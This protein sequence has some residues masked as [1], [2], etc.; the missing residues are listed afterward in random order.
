[1]PT[2][3]FTDALT[4]KDE[5]FPKKPDKLLEHER[6]RGVDLDDLSVDDGLVHSI[7]YLITERRKR[8]SDEWAHLKVKL[9]TLAK[10]D[11]RRLI[12]EIETQADPLILW[13]LHLTLN[14]RGVPPAQ[15]WPVNMFGT[16]QSRFI[17]VLADLHWLVKRHPKHA[18]PSMST[19]W[20]ELFKL[21]PER[22]AW[23]TTAHLLYK[24]L[25]QPNISSSGARAIALT[26][27]QRQNM[28]AFPTAAMRRSRQQLGADEH[29]KTHQA[30]HSAAIANRY[31]A[32]A[33]NPLQ[34][35]NH[36]STLWRVYVLS[37]CSLTET[38][39]NWKLITGEDLTRQAI[40]K[41]ITTIKTALK[42]HL[43]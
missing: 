30:L 40:T 36:R 6:P 10:L 39:K 2:A 31:K 28:M 35:A 24:K 29:E 3:P 37:D 32:K 19:G 27:S 9:T 4:D 17:T 13:I 14:E 34:A 33:F 41:Q 15:R 25:S 16:A 42:R 43:I 26:P 21:V 22:S 38:T 8:T 11:T 5:T 1:M 7:L 12:E 18:P 20:Q 23:H